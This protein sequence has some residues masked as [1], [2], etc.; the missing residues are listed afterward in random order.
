MRM[1]H[2]SAAWVLAAAV[3]ALIAA[4]CQ[5]L[6][7]APQGEGPE[8]MGR[9]ILRVNVTRQGFYPRRPWQ[10]EPPVSVS[11]IGVIRPGGRV[12]VSA[13]TIADHRFIEV[14]K[15]DTGQKCQ[16][17]VE[18][19][20][21]EADLALVICRDPGFMED[22]QA[23]ALADEV[24]P[25]D[26]LE[27]LQVQP[28][29]RIIASSA[30]VETVELGDYPY[31]NQFLVYRLSGSVQNRH[32]NLTL[33]VVC[34]GRLA[35]LLKPKEN[36]EDI[37]EATPV[38]LIA[39]FLADIADGNYRGFPI[40]GIRS[41]PTEDP[42]LRRWAELEPDGLGVL[43]D[44]VFAG[45][46]ADR[47]GIRTGDVLMAI[48]GHSVDSRGYY[49]DPRLGRIGIAHLIRCGYHVGDRAR[50]TLRREG[51]LLNAD[52]QMDRPSSEA[53]LVPP[54][55]HD[56]PPRYYLIN[57]LVLQELSAPYLKDFGGDWIFNAPISLLYYY[58]NQYELKRPVGEKIVVLNAVLPTSA[59]IGYEQINNAVIIR[60]NDRPIHRLEDVPLSLET[61]KDGFQRIDIDLPPFRI[62]LDPKQSAAVDEEVRQRYDLTTLYNL[63]P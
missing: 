29:G 30:R 62:Y 49:V 39:H 58:Q 40:S 25:G 44:N 48:D 50:F 21:Y 22:M 15:I 42:Q 20:D 55:R 24:L 38:P 5:T 10:P 12:L 9:H 32:D 28:S 23:L 36:P 16:A 31:G 35:G 59:T 4:G 37:I 13:E 53:Y 27:V 6:R 26:R 1:R 19:V 57:G 52:L 41:V 14:E 17:V 34:G 3:A 11:A 8:K 60:I 47:A 43:V 45:S 61:P 7:Y 18:A 54:Y 56:R 2:A 51:R 33:P 63:D 46:A